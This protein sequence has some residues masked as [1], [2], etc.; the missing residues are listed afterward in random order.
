V[1]SHIYLVGRIC[2]SDNELRSMKAELSAAAKH[3]ISLLFHCAVAWATLATD[4]FVCLQ[5]TIACGDYSATLTAQ[6]LRRRSSLLKHNILISLH[7]LL[8]SAAEEHF[9]K[10]HLW[11]SKLLSR[12]VSR[13]SLGEVG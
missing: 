12:V 9:R 3:S 4:S 13:S 5:W 1:A 8:Y 7:D 11:V 2:V 6:K 10:G